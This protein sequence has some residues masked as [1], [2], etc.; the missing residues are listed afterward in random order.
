MSLPKEDQA[1]TLSGGDTAMGQRM[2]HFSEYSGRVEE[3]Y[4]PEDGS[5][6]LGA[7]ILIADAEWAEQ[8]ARRADS[9][10]DWC[11]GRMG[12]GMRTGR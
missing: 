7:S 8:E 2:V 10:P 9:Q 3:I 1:K 11:S 12:R 5:T 6:E 4:L